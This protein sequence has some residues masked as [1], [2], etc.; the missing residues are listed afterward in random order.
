MTKQVTL[1]KFSDK[2]DIEEFVEKLESFERGELTVDQF[3]AFRLLR[4]V[5]GQRQ[6]DVQMFR[7]KIPMGLMGPE[8]LVAVADVTDEY[9]R[10]FG[11]VTTRQ[12]IQ[13]HFVKLGGLGGRAAPPRRGGADDA[14]GLRELGSQRDRV[15][16]RRGLRARSLRR[17]ALCRGHRPALPPPSALQQPSAKIQDRLQ[18]LRSRLRVRRH[19][20]PG[21]HRDGEGRRAGLQG[22]RGRGP[23][24]DTPGRHHAARVHPCSGARPGRRGAGPSLSRARQSR[25]QAPRADEVRASQAG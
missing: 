3:R 6:P 25:Q 24:D 13:L 2:K 5:Y 1:P 19:P 4:G 11:H 9:S 20:R 14:G 10:G 22:V 12:N 17:D 18:R 23:V 7:I 16:A 15:R 8:Q 21:S